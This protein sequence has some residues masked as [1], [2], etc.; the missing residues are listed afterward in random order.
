MLLF[1]HTSYI[2]FHT[3]AGTAVGISVMVHV[4]HFLIH[5]S[6]QVSNCCSEVVTRNWWLIRILVQD[7]SKGNFEGFQLFDIVN[8]LGEQVSEAFWFYP[9][10]I[11]IYA[12]ETERWALWLNNNI[13][14]LKLWLRDV[15]CFRILDLYAV[16]GLFLWDLPGV[17]NGLRCKDIR[18]S[19]LRDPSNPV[20]SSQRYV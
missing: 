11:V 19:F 5:G 10:W 15:P 1:L 16:W 4:L 14:A 7:S 2:H 18:C 8:L 3:W 17:D 6:S 9:Q 20:R 13:F 12:V